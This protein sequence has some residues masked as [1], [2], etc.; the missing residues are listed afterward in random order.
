LGAFH[1][2]DDFCLARLATALDAR[3]FREAADLME[4]ALERLFG[5]REEC[6]QRRTAEGPPQRTVFGD[7][8]LFQRPCAER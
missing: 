3:A 7:L 5:L 6:L 1:A 2:R 8:L 4:D